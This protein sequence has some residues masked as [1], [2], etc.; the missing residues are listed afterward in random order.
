M[1]HNQTYRIQVVIHTEDGSSFELNQIEL[2]D[3]TQSST[4]I[5]LALLD[6]VREKQS[7]LVEGLDDIRG[8]RQTKYNPQYIKVGA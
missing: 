7:A 6:C 5:V 2:H 4:S 8:I 1:A 3:N